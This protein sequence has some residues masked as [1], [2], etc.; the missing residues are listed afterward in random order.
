MGIIVLERKSDES[1][2]Q[3]NNNKVDSINTRRIFIA[4]LLHISD[5]ENY[6]F[7]IPL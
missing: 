2:M 4:H 1:S 3:E 6:F 7:I 5:Q